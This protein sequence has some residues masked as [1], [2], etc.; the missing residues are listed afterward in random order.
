MNRTRTNHTD[1]LSICDQNETHILIN[2]ASEL[3]IHH[4]EQWYS[5]EPTKLIHCGA[6]FI[7]Q[8]YR[9]S[10]YNALNELFPEY[11]W[12]S[13]RFYKNVTNWEDPKIIRQFF[14]WASNKLG[15][16]KIN[17]WYKVKA[18]DL[19]NLGLPMNQLKLD[20][21]TLITI[22]YPEYEWHVWLFDIVPNGFWDNLENHRRYLHWFAEK[23]NITNPNDWYS[24]QAIDFMSR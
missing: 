4:P 15:I 22:A 16:Y 3:A 8:N 2:I 23:H 6:K 10:L 14:D 11:Y 5:I 12:Q 9:G 19:E 13:W 18:K 24:I 21:H 20:I 17:S 7:K 1:K